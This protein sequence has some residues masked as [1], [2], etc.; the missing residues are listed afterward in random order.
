MYAR[1]NEVATGGDLR[2][3]QNV[4][5]VYRGRVQKFQD[6]GVPAAEPD[7]LVQVAARRAL[8]RLAKQPVA[9]IAVDHPPRCPIPDC[10][11]RV[12]LAASAGQDR[13][14]V[15]GAAR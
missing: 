3:D 9:I 12:V 6:V 5:P 7:P 13:P 10:D 14:R 2:R 1:T 4:E 11:V 15:H 8:V